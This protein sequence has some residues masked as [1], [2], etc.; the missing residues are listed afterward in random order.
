VEYNRQ[1]RVLAHIFIRAVAG[2][3]SVM[4]FLRHK[5]SSAL[6]ACIQFGFVGKDKD[7][8]CKSGTK[9]TLLG[10]STAHRIP[11]CSLQVLH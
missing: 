7:D 6:T 10:V 4:I 3:C 11:L 2:F 5:A 8:K 1:H 9:A